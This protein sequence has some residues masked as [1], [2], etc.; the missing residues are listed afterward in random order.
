[1]R[2]NREQGIVRDIGIQTRKRLHI[3]ILTRKS[4]FSTKQKEETRKKPKPEEQE[5]MPTNDYIPVG[6]H[7]QAHKYRATAIGVAIEHQDT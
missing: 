2:I 5:G 6:V 4:S 1:L 7:E 3:K